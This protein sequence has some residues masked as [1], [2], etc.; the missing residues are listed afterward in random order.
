MTS[1]HIDRETPPP[2]ILPGHHTVVLTPYGSLF[3]ASASVFESQLPRVE[4]TS[5]SSVVVI[6]M[7]GKE[8]LG[9]TFITIMLRYHD[10]LQTVGSHLVLTGLSE[11][12]HAQLHRTGALERLGRDNIFAATPRI[13]ESLKAGLQRAQTLLGQ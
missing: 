3:F 2:A 5:T 10:S 11:R 4:A 7:R 1:T 6:S 13:G 12:V 9:A 8:D